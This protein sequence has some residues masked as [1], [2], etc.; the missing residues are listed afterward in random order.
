MMKKLTI[1]FLLAGGR[2]HGRKPNEVVSVHPD[3]L[4]LAAALKLKDHKVGLVVVIK[5][6]KLV[7][8][9]SER[10]VVRKWVCGRK[11]PQPVKVSELMT[12]N[13][14]VVT[15]NDTVFD[16]YLRFIARN[17]RHLPVVDP[18][19]QVLGI[20]SM[21]DVTTYVINRLEEHQGKI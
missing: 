13:V 19:G 12:P 7:G 1:D 6:Q 16:C 21:R 5:D 3:D 2:E 14:E 10:D 18:L 17:C 9:L 4:V 8:V 11:F 20:L 15:P